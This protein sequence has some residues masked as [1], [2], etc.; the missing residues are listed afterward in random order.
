MLLILHFMFQTG[1]GIHG[2]CPQLYF[3]KVPSRIVPQD[4]RKGRRH[5]QDQMI[6]AV[7]IGLGMA[8]IVFFLY[9]FYLRQMA[10]AVD[11]GINIV[12][13]PADDAQTVSAAV[14]A[15]CASVGVSSTVPVGVA[16]SVVYLAASSPPS[17]IV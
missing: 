3:R 7:S 14:M 2:Q 1:P 12:D 15:R 9:Y 10:Y 16:Q 13:N 4:I 6:A 8:D 17:A 11:I 5:R